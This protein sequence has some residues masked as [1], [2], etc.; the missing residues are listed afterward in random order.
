MAGC[1]GGIALGAAND[2]SN[3]DQ[4]K[5]ASWRSHPDLGL[6][7]TTFLASVFIFRPV[8]QPAV[9]TAS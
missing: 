4:L 7:V 2:R 1:R 3:R 6:Y 8:A 5:R 9:I